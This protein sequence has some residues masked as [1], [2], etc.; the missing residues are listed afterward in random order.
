MNI[1]KE[2]KDLE[3]LRDH[4]YK[5]LNDVRSGEITITDA[6]LTARLSDNIIKTYLLE[7]GL[8]KKNQKKI[9]I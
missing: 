6:K 7:I 5:T 3:S 1:L 4:L 8:N 2:I 9:E